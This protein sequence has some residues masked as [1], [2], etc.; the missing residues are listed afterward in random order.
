VQLSYQID[1]DELR[2]IEPS[3][4]EVSVHARTLA[5]AYNE[6]RNAPLLGHTA[7]MTEA[8]VLEHYESLYAHGARPFL[9]LVDGALAGDADV[10][11]IALGKAEFAFLIA[12]PD[13]QGKGLGTRF[14]TMIHAYAFAKLG[15]DRMFASVIPVNVA[16]RRV[17]EKLGYHTDDSDAARGFAD[18]GDV[19]MSLDRGTFERRHAA[20]VADIRIRTR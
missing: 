13:R 19:T 3:L 1:W 8:E 15:V 5:E 7:A 4:D 18:P 14:A 12:S 11:G 16:S 20:V 10:R 9:L 6:P 17:F 2:A